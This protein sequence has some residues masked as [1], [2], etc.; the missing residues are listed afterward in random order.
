MKH[1]LFALA[2]NAA[3][4]RPGI[5]NVPTVAQRVETV[6][7]KVRHNRRQKEPVVTEPKTER[8]ALLSIE[9]GVDIGSA[10]RPPGRRCACR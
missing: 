7:A 5:P 9:T 8:I 6:R 10:R 1:D 2:N 4:G 3:R